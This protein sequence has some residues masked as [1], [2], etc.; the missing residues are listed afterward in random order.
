M[1]EMSMI[2]ESVSKKRIFPPRY[3]FIEAKSWICW[4]ICSLDVKEGVH[5]IRTLYN[6]DV[7]AR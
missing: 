6:Y 2:I 1:L 5:F 7:I 3:I 4:K